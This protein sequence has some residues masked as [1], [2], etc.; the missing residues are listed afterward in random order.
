MRISISVDVAAILYTLSAVLFILALRGLSSPE[1]SRKGNVFGM[2]GIAIAIITTALSAGLWGQ[3]LLFAFT[4][5]AIGGL[6]GAVIAKKIPMTDM[7]QLVAAFHSLVGLAAVLVA[8]A[9]FFSP[10]SFGILSDNG[11]KPASLL[12][13]GLGAAIGAITFSGS[14]IAFAKLNGNMSGAP[15]LLP[16]RHLING[17]LLVCIVTTLVMLMKTGGNNP[18]FIWVL[19]A[20]TFVI[21]FSINYPYRRC[22]YAS[23]CFNAE[24][25]FR[26]GSSCFGFHF[27]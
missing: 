11:I 5:M 19:L 23:G 27:G 18:S 26:L 20:L 24:L 15:I 22:G 12:E 13:L 25:I 1:S 6:L 17:A 14:V 7:P 8:I 16:F 10:E 3:S 2:L 9:A 21:G 4:A